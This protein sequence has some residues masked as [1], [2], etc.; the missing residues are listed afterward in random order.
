MIEAN[1]L[2]GTET[3]EFAGK[4]AHTRWGTIMVAMLIVSEPDDYGTILNVFTRAGKG[5]SYDG[6]DKFVLSAGAPNVTSA[7]IAAQLSKI[8]TVAIIGALIDLF[9]PIAL[10]GS[11]QQKQGISLSESRSLRDTMTSDMKKMR[12]CDCPFEGDEGRGPSGKP[13]Q[14]HGDGCTV[15]KACNHHDWRAF[16]AKVRRICAEFGATLKQT[17]G[18]TPAWIDGEI[19]RL[20]HCMHESQKEYEHDLPLMDALVALF[21]AYDVP[22]DRTNA[23]L[24]IH[25][26]EAIGVLTDRYFSGDSANLFGTAEDFKAEHEQFRHEFIRRGEKYKDNILTTANK[27]LRKEW[28][29]GRKKFLATNKKRVKDGKAPLVGGPY[30]FAFFP[31]RTRVRPE[32]LVAAVRKRT[33]L[34]ERHPI[35]SR[36]SAFLQVFMPNNAVTEAVFSG[37]KVCVLHPLRFW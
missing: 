29:A 20:K 34:F 8:E 36:M 18:R 16:V 19:H 21:D 5:D 37:M 1:A 17:A 3:G 26:E 27:P 14:V 7:G 35:M 6:T 15:A 4:V 32:E 30:D 9:Q 33:D 28:D 24:D 31:A 23:S 22:D 12:E 11:K 10:C 25:F 13:R 2:L